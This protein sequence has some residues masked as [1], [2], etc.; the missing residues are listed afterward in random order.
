[1]LKTNNELDVRKLWNFRAIDEASALSEAASM[2]TAENQLSLFD[3]QGNTAGVCP[4]CG[5]SLPQCLT[6]GARLEPNP[7]ERR[8]R[9]YCSDSCR[10]MAYHHRKKQTREE[11]RL[12]FAQAV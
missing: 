3:A 8:P 11:N 9:K 1:M 5:Q 7:Q 4:C 6:C 2:A 12:R 10:V